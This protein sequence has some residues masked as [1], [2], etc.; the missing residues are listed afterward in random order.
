MF[1]SGH[2]RKHFPGMKK[3]QA[4]G[5]PADDELQA[6]TLPL[7][8]KRIKPLPGALPHE[9]GELGKRGRNTWSTI[10]VANIK[11]KLFAETELR[12]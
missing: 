5:R 4:P 2:P 10:T 12:N 11:S 9:A 8:W 6:S 3:Q 7:K 1:Q